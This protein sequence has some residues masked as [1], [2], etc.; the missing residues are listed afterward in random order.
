[1]SS[2]I[3]FRSVNGI[4][5]QPFDEVDISHSVFD[6]YADT[7]TI[8]R[9]TISNYKRSP[10]LR[11][12]RKLFTDDYAII[13]PFILFN[14][15]SIHSDVIMIEACV[16]LPNN[17]GF[18]VP[19]HHGEDSHSLFEYRGIQFDINEREPTIAT[20][21]IYLLYDSQ[22]VDPSQ[23]FNGYEYFGT[24]YKYMRTN[25]EYTIFRTERR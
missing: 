24:V 1:M 14:V 10:I 12:T 20:C 2:N 5:L 16:E 17:R 13:Q 22:P 19:L 21:G 7:H 3:V 6:V 23:P 25:G 8:I 15:Q 9:N 18:T 11:L 4:H